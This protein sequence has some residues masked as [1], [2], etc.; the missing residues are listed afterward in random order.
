[1]SAERSF[2]VAL[3]GTS[4]VGKT[5]VIED[6][7]SYY[8]EN[9]TVIF[10]PEAARA[11][12]EDTPTSDRFSAETQ[13]Q[14]QQR[15]INNEKAGHANGT[16]LVCDRSAFDAAAYTL[17]NGDMPGAT[18][19]VEHI[20]DWIPTYT[21]LVL[22]DPKDVPYYKDDIR[23][24]DESYRQTI[25]NAF[26]QLLEMHKIPHIVLSGTLEQRVNKVNEI[27]ASHT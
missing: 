15:A 3:I 13:K 16:I 6:L 21:I 7:K 19:L 8:R 9:P 25:H 24:E 20:K 23:T 10:I 18:E 5:S 2:K 12:F 4:C 11:F 14:I 27:I 17:A 22:L 26:V 1:M